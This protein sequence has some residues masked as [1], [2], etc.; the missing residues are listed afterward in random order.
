MKANER[1]WLAE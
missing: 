1:G